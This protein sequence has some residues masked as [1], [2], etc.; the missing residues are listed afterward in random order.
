MSLGLTKKSWRVVDA[1]DPEKPVFSC[2]T[3]TE[4]REKKAEQEQKDAKHGNKRELKIVPHEKLVTRGRDLSKLD[5][6]WEAPIFVTKLPCGYDLVR[7]NTDKDVYQ[8]GQMM[9]HC[10]DR[11]DRRKSAE[12]N[13]FF[14]F[15]PID[16]KGTPHGTLHARN[17]ELFGSRTGVQGYDY[18]AYSLGWGAKY[19]V[20]PPTPL[21]FEEWKKEETERQKAAWE[22]QVARYDQIYGEDWYARNYGGRTFRPN[23]PRYNYDYYLLNLKQNLPGKIYPAVLGEFRIIALS[24]YAKGYATQAPWVD[25]AKTWWE[26][27]IDWD[28]ESIPI[29]RGYSY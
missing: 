23:V 12:D 18:Q 8:F 19:D 21:S 3:R 24:C 28:G 16:E 27:L 15:T 17:A 2:K 11:P 7:L 10:A 13:D 14:F 20:E 6:K 9:G 22:A 4:A 5:V 26:S 29:K 1:S 25:E